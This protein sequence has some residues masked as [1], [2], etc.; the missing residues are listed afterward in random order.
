MTHWSRPTVACVAPSSMWWEELQGMAMP[1]TVA[2]RS[3]VSS[4]LVDRGADLGFSQITAPA[5]GPQGCPDVSPT[6][7]LSQTFQG[8]VFLAQDPQAG[9]PGM[10]SDLLFLEWGNFCNVVVPPFMGCS[11]PAPRGA[12]LSCAVTQPFGLCHRCSFFTSLVVEGLPW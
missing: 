1:V 7:L 3:S 8:R 4:I 12:G 6:G 11:P 5:P 9:E 2:P 10:G